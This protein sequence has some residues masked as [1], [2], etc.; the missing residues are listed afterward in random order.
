MRNACKSLTQISLALSLFVACAALARAQSRDPHVVSALAGG[1]N[2][3]T[4]DVTMR[5]AEHQSWQSL[6]QTD[7]LRSGDTVRTGADGRAEVLLNPGSYLRLGENSELELTDSSL[8][9]LRL[10]LTRGSAL[11]E[12]S[13][14]DAPA[15]SAL[16]AAPQTKDSIHNASARRP[17]GFVIEIDTA[18][19]QVVIVRSGIYRVNAGNT[20][21]LYVRDGRALVGR[22]GVLVKGGN[23]ATIAT[24]G[25]VEVA[26]FDKK[27]KDD[28]DVWSKHRAGEL[29]R[30]NSR[31]PV[32]ALNAT[33]VSM[34]W[35]IFNWGGSPTG[36]WFYDWTALSYAYV[37]FFSCRSP[38]GYAYNIAAPGLLNTCDCYRGFDYRQPGVPSIVRNGNGGGGTITGGGTSG[39]GT[40]I[41]GG[42]TLGG[43]TLGSGSINT[44]TSGDNAPTTPHTGGG[45]SHRIEPPL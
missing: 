32:R 34:R 40:T 31:L 33:L 5:R 25:A 4:G 17:E 29:A 14:Y 9:T 22:D 12:A 6:R 42:S 38:Y 45:S 21:E 3:V 1:V 39:G 18:Q 10:K 15:S 30:V 26:K 44:R 8:N 35:E 2:F 28:L 24:G 13:L 19:T 41:G 23:S 37:P 11:V 27:Q 7:D 36:F 20:T 43:S 16:L